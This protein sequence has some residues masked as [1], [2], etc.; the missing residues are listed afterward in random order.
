MRSTAVLVS[1]LVISVSS[2][3][4]HAEAGVTGTGPAT[5]IDARAMVGPAAGT[6][7]DRSEKEALIAAKRWR[8]KNWPAYRDWWDFK[9]SKNPWCHSGGIYKNTEGKLL[10]KGIERYLEY[11]VNCYP[12]KG[13]QRDGERIVVGFVHASDKVEYCIVYTADH[14]RNFRA[15]TGKNCRK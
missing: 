3:G 8:S 15:L 9:Y 1:A 11:D 13:H 6:A 10:T 12:T 14:Y 7:G 2:G 5:R 4:F